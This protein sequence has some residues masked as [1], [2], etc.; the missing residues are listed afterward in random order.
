MYCKPTLTTM[1]WVAT[2]NKWRAILLSFLIGES[3]GQQIPELKR[4][5]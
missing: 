1:G 5:F 3:K 2:G 4:Y